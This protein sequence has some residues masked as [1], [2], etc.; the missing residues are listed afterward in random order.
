MRILCFLLLL[1]TLQSCATKKYTKAHLLPE[2]IKSATE[3]RYNI[4]NSQKKLL[5][6]KEITFKN[7]RIKHSKTFDSS[8]KLTQETNKKMWFTEE[9]YPNKKTLYRKTRWKPNRRERI[10]TYLKKQDK[11]SESIYHYN[12]DGS[13]NKIVDNF[14]TFQTQHF[15]YT[16]NELSKIEITSKDGKIVD[17]VSIDCK[18][19]DN[20]GTCIKQMRTSIKKGTK[21]E[22]IITPVYD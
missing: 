20:Q 8:G 3:E 2:G 7:G 22:I 15:Y 19:K 5:Q 1:F 10:S 9:L 18:E 4:S 11:Q 14:S 13:I 12:K 17:E 16:H 6:K 21:E